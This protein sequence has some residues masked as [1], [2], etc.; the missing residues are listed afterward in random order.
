M[1]RNCIFV[2]LFIK[3]LFRHLLLLFLFFFFFFF[4]FSRFLFNMTICQSTY[5]KVSFILLIMFLYM[6]PAVF[7]F[8]LF[9]FLCFVCFSF[10]QKD[11]KKFFGLIFLQRT[12]TESFTYI[13]ISAACND[14]M[15]LLLCHVTLTW[16]NKVC[17]CL[18]ASASDSRCFDSCPASEHNY[19]RKR[20]GEVD[21]AHQ[22]FTIL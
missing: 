10:L 19:E 5:L 14:N 21:C 1:P 3:C 20:E 16:G 13:V 6:C 12:S 11:L 22:F 7:C 9:F 17:V 15:L 18:S 8:V 4:I 2:V